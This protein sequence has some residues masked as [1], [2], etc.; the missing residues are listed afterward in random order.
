GPPE[1]RP[2]VQALLTQVYDKDIEFRDKGEPA[3]RGWKPVEVIEVCE[4]VVCDAGSWRVSAE[5]VEHGHGLDFPAAF[6]HRWTCLGYR[7]ECADG[8]IAI[9]G[10]TVECDG[11]YRLAQ[12]ADILVQCCYLAAAELTNESMQLLATHTLACGDKVGKI[13]TRANVKTLVLTH[14][15]RKPAAMLETLAAEVRRDFTGRLIIGADLMSI[16]L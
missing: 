16:E 10:D 9:S 8:V 1:T 7:F 3:N 14:H 2:I 6:R 15:R 4:G 5:M 13:A 12:D 11:L